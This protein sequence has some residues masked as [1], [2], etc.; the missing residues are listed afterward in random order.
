MTR[1]V[2]VTRGF[3]Y[4]V[5]AS[6][7]RVRE[8]GGVSKLTDAEKK[9]LVWKEV[10]IGDDC[11]DMPAESLAHYLQRGDVAVLAAEPEKVVKAKK[12]KG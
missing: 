7:D 10:S 12:G 11:S 2:A 5:G 1:Y 3:R 6:L 4:P 9:A 8:A